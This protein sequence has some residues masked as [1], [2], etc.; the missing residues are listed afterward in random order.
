MP[1]E[2]QKKWGV[3]L[4]AMHLELFPPFDNVCGYDLSREGLLRPN[5]LRLLRLLEKGVSSADWTLGA[6][7]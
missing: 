7:S 4:H 1:Q 3:K 2:S 5:S 6:T